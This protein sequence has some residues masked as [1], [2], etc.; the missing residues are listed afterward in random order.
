MPKAHMVLSDFEFF[1]EEP[2]NND[3]NFAYPRK[4]RPSVHATINGKTK[5]YSSIMRAPKYGADI[6]FPTN[7]SDL[8]AL[9]KSLSTSTATSEVYRH[10]EFMK[11]FGDKKVI[12]SIKTLDGYN[13]LLTDYDNTKFFI[14]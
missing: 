6:Y 3:P 4:N 10:S 2:E 7:F 5:I 13:P 12:E 14:S 8:S 9:Y 11:K 1:P